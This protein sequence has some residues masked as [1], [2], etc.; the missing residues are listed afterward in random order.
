MALFWEKYLSKMQVFLEVFKYKYKY[1]TLEICVGKIL[2]N[3]TGKRLARKNLANNITYSEC[4]FFGVFIN[5]GR[6]K[7]W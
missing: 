3:H 5:I 2:V 6:E 1:R 4:I 7:F